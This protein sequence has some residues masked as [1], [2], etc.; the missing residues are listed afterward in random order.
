MNQDQ[1][2]FDFQLKALFMFNPLAIPTVPK[3]SEQVI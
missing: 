2:Q 3:P 1:L